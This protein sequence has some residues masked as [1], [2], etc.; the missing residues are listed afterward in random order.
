MWQVY[1]ATHCTELIMSQTNEKLKTRQ[2][3]LTLTPPPDYNVV[4][5]NDAVTTFEFVIGSLQE[6]FNYTQDPA[7]NKAMEINNKG[8][9]IVAT[10]PFEIAEQKGVEVL[11]QARN[12]GY[13]LEVRLEESI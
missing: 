11:L 9:G 13:P 8:S 1:S 2:K 12:N 10:L 4:Y 7:V 3:N 6:T 5:V